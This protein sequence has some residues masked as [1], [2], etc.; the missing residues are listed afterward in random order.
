MLVCVLRE[1][2]GK[3]GAPRGPLSPK[4][5]TH[6]GAENTPTHTGGPKT[7]PHTHGAPQNRS[8]IGLGRGDKGERFPTVTNFQVLGIIHVCTLYFSIKIPQLALIMHWG[9]LAICAFL[10]YILY[11]KAYCA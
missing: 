3:I 8:V 6:T 11:I 4:S 1:K 5:H 10:I 9:K 7:A 2:G